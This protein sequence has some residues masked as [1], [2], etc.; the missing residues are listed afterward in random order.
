ML[1]LIF[2]YDFKAMIQIKE[3]DKIL[4]HVCFAGS[5]SP[6]CEF[7]MF[8]SFSFCV[9]LFMLLTSFFLLLQLF[10]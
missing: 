6:F 4:L 10:E 2:L 3:N 5:F 9:I 7:D 1:Y 8:R